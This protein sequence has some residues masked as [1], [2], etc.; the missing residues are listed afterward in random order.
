MQ[1]NFLSHY[2]AYTQDTECP[3]TF[4]RWSALSL[5][6]AWIG[7]NL[8]LGLGHFKVKP[9]MYVMLMG[10][11]G[12]RKSTAIKI[13]SKTLIGAGYSRVAADRSTKEKFLLDLAGEPDEHAT[14]SD[15]LDANIFGA[16]T[17]D[18]AEIMIAADEFN[19]FIGNGNIE[20]LS[21][22]GVLWDYD[23][24]FKNRVKNSKSVEIKDPTV[25]ILAGNTPTGFS[26]AFPV[27][28]IGQGIFSR[29][30]LVHGETSGKKITFPLPPT[31][32]ATAAI[33][34]HLVAIRRECVGTLRL[35]L[36]AESLL[37]KIYRGHSGIGDV[38]FESYS[39]R[40]FTHLL[41]LCII[42]C[43]ARLSVVIEEEDVILANTILT[44]TEHSMPQALG[45]FGKARNSDVSH[46]ILQVLETSQGLVSL[47]DLW[48]HVHTDLD[49]MGD[50][51]DILRNLVAAEKIIQHSTGF[52]LRRKVIEEVSDGLVDFTLLTA[53][54]RKYVS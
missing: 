23:G 20:F 35:T 43:A 11:P 50:L 15:D 19:S 26:L 40:R 24:I 36:S 13:A 46:K 39:N 28:S 6:G 27:E 1:E 14:P 17:C 41:K 18:A 42:V 44:H 5:L 54:E 45:T 31:Q 48:T 33:L 29:I 22:L 47:K 9:N 12:T 32:E 38:R 8:S 34:E 52:L 7:P 4:H 21:M 49:R 25:S 37:D 53:E 2:L 3:T 30:I 51:A 10:S 16:Q